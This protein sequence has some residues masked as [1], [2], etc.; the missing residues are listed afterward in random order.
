MTK[1]E[2]DIWGDDSES[3][4]LWNA[5]ARKPIRL[6]DIYTRQPRPKAHRMADMPKSKAAAI[7]RDWYGD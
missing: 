6:R 2:I 3:C 4:R 5:A 1:P 7:Y